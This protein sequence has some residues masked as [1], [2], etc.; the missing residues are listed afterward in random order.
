MPRTRCATRSGS[1]P[2]SRSRTPVALLGHEFGVPVDVAAALE[3][4]ERSRRH[5]TDR[6]RSQLAVIAA[7]I[8]GT[9]EDLVARHLAE[10]PRD[11]LILSAAVPTIAFAGVYDV[12]EQAWALVEGL[13]PAYGTDWWFQGLLAFVRQEQERWSEAAALADRALD[14]EPASGHA[15]HA[16]AH[17]YYETGDH[18][19]GLSWLD[20]WIAS[21]GLGSQHRAHFSWHAALHELSDGDAAAVRRRYADQL[22]P[23]Q[24]R[25]AR[26]LVDSASLLWRGVLDDVWTGP[27]PIGPVLAAVEPELVT[28]PT[29]GFGALHA[30]VALLT[31]GDVAGLERLE[32]YAATAPAAVLREVAAPLIGGLRAFA[33]GCYDTAADRLVSITPRLIRLGGSAAQ[34][35]VV[36]DTLLHALM[37]AGRM[38]EARALLVH[39][40]DRRPSRRDLHR[41]SRSYR[42]PSLV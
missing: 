27:V 33:E 2:A 39:R 26:A 24:V 30:A 32:A 31:A 28:R 11:V 19:E 3:A 6:E 15:A 21:S 9:G 13:A 5:C 17:V 40:L 1:T 4:A 38:A 34:R 12:P 16:R 18:A 35:E 7:R 36:E 41:L 42:T 25:G 37:N 29:T 23:P 10:Y 22:A 8:R 14:L 20:G